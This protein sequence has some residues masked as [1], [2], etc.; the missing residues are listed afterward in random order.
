MKERGISGQTAKV[1]TNTLNKVLKVEA[2]STSCLVLYQ[3]KVPNA[4][5]RFRSEK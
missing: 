1:V 5:K 3:P 4:L 2:N